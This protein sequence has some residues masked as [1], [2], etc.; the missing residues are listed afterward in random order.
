MYQFTRRNT[1][2]FERPLIQLENEKITYVRFMIDYVLFT[3]YIITTSMN[4]CGTR[5]HIY[6]YIYIYMHRPKQCHVTNT[7]QSKEGSGMDT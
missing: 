5:V 6:I 3:N 4:K 1:R 7:V 2:K